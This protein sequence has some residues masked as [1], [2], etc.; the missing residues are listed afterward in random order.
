M[1]N[2]DILQQLYRKRIR[3]WN[4][5]FPNSRTCSMFVSKRLKIQCYSTTAFGNSLKHFATTNTVVA[6]L[7]QNLEILK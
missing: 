2:F 4:M 3:I 7:S 6:Q 1:A 5:H